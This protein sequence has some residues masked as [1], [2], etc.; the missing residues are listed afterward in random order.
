[1]LKTARSPLRCL[2]SIALAW[3]ACSGPSSYAVQQDVKAGNFEGAARRLE[4]NRD[5]KPKDFETRL[6]LADVYYQLARKAV[7]D[8]KPDAYVEYLRKAQV[9]ILEATKID[10]ASPRPHTQMGIVAAY[11]GDLD[12]SETSF[13]NALRLSLRDRFQ[14]PPPTC[15]SNLAHI[16]V[17]QGK[18]SEARRYLD[19]AERGGAPEDEIARISVLASWKENDMTEARDA[20]NNAVLTSRPFAETW[21]EAALPQPMK[22]FGDFAEVCCKNPTCGPH[23]EGACKRERQEVAK[24]Q[25]DRDTLQKEMQLERE[26]RQ[27]LKD[28]YQKR[29]DI[30]ITVD[31]PNAP[32]KRSE[33][34]GP[35]VPAPSAPSTPTSRPAPQR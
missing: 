21:D 7:D 6:A 32:A 10:P 4:N 31:D 30:E 11:Q 29:R 34:T 1:M 22:T 19:K 33:S 23:M 35:A 2:V 13:R 16:A 26:R 28:I 8:G 24:R 27:A 9:E 20:F 25:I 12:A 5:A 18:L 14:S 15:Y 17:Y 3:A